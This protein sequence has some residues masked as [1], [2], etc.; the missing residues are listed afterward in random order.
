M[1]IDE[2]VHESEVGAKDNR[3][4]IRSIADFIEAVEEDY[5]G[6][7][8]EQEPWFRGEPGETDT[9][10]LPTVFRK[11]RDENALLQFFRMRAPSALDI[12]HIP[13]RGEIDLWLFLARHLE[14]PT[15]LLDWTEGALVALWF[16]LQEDDPVV[17][18]LNPLALNRKMDPGLVP[19]APTITWTSPGGEDSINIAFA[20]IKAAWSAAS[21][22]LTLPV[23]VYPTHV[24]GYMSGQ[25]S[26]FT[27]QGSA[28]ESLNRILGPECLCRY[29]IDLDTD[30]PF[31]ELRSLGISGSAV[32]PGSRGLVGELSERF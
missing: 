21:S 32:F 12:D 16:A 20:N 29:E 6:W 15:R 7:D 31:R 1:P 22:A 30:D 8:T 2:D 24:H 5:A 4:P 10:L 13:D 11:D 23:A 3:D 18:M 9:P 26:V 27:V 25:H 28:H 14:L 17:W 19:N